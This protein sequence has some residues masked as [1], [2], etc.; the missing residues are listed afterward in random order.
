MSQNIRIVSE[1][2]ESEGVSWDD[3]LETTRHTT[4]GRP[5]VGRGGGLP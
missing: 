3:N 5:K 2:L 4:L 1:T